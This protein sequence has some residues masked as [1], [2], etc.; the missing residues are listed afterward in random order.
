MTKDVVSGQAE[1]L[2]VQ[3]PV[4]PTP[5]ACSSLLATASPPLAHCPLQEPYTVVGGNPAKVIRRLKPGEPREAA[6][7]EQPP[8]K[9]QK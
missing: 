5:L 2:A 6:G 1:R 3:R 7:V 9:R 4:A 8:Q